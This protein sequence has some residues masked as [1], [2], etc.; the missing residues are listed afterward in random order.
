M[1]DYEKR[2]LKIKWAS[3]GIS[4]SLLAMATY[5]YDKNA[6]MELKKP[7]IAAQVKACEQIIDLVAEVSQITSIKER[8]SRLT[9]LKKLYFSKGS[10]FLDDEGLT[11]FRKFNS[12]IENCLDKPEINECHHLNLGS[13]PFDLAQ[14]CRNSSVTTWSSNPEEWAQPIEKNL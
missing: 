5:T 9:E 13:Y 8:H 1:N 10:M 12:N 7:F 14:A 6:E 3:L 11:I 2:D 4:A